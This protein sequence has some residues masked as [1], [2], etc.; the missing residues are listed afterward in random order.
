ML[1]YNTTYHT[2]SSCYQEFIDWLKLEYI[3]AAMQRGILGKPRLSRILTEEKDAGISISLQFD[4]DDLDKLSHWYKTCGANL[5]NTLQ[6]KF[7]QQIAGFSTIM[8][9]IDL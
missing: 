4:V 9:Q 5:I 2:E 7:G 1:I 3:P 8:E 6:Q